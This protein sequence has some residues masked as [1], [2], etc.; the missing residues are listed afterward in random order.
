MAS[1]RI[2]MKQ[3]HRIKLE[4]GGELALVERSYQ[5][6]DD[7]IQAKLVADGLAVLE[8]DVLDGKLDAATLEPPVVVFPPA[9]DGG[10]GTV[11]AAVIGDA[12]APVDESTEFSDDDSAEADEE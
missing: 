4:G 1:Q 7:A 12:A 11:T 5:L 8:Q 2:I 3:T 10:F 9:G 6:L